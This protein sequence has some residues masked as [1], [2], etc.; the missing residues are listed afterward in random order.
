[1]GTFQIGDGQTLIVVVEP[2]RI[3]VVVVVEGGAIRTTCFEKE[4]AK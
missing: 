2:E 4:G 1:M 3:L